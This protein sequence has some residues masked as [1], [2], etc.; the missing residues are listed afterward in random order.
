MLKFKKFGLIEVQH[1]R[2]QWRL[3]RAEQSDWATWS[4]K[5]RS[6]KQR[7][8]SLWLS[9]ERQITS[10]TEICRPDEIEIGHFNVVRLID[11]HV[12]IGSFDPNSSVSLSRAE[13]SDR[14]TWSS[15]CRARPQDRRLKWCGRNKTKQNRR[16][17]FSHFFNWALWRFNTLLRIK[18]CRIN[19]LICLDSH[20]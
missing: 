11:Q 14:A 8:I 19:I 18:W 17:C 5:Q 20:R 15:K 3:S 2:E 12:Q 13:Q 16:H 7:P 6:S 9:P 10:L 1:W 4:S